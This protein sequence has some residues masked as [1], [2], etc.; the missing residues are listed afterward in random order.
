MRTLCVGSGCYLEDAPLIVGSPIAR[1][2]VEVA[3]S[4]LGQSRVGFYTI[5][6]IGL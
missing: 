3:V 4:G 5:R 1:C 2:P 6:A